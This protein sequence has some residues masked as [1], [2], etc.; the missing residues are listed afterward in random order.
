MLAKLGFEPVGRGLIGCAARGH[1]VEAVTYWLDHKRAALAI[2]LLTAE[3]TEQ[4]RW[5]TW[6]G[7][8]RTA[9]G[10]VAP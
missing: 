10:G 2:P 6:L 9:R 4:P 8:L 5:R 7:R 3:P 1:D